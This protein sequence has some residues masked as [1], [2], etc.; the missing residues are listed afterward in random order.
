M[1]ALFIILGIIGWF[2]LG[3]LGYII[4][5]KFGDEDISDEF[6]LYFATGAMSFCILILLVIYE[7]I[8]DFITSVF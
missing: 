6:G 5:Q 4:Y 1:I 7:R 2:I 8:R 3:I